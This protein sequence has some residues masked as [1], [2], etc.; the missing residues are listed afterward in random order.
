MNIERGSR[1]TATNRRRRLHRVRSTATLKQ[2]SREERGA[3]PSA[4]KRRKNSGETAQ[5]HSQVQSI[6]K[7]RVCAQDRKE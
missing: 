3:E 1:A 5:R 2:M 6:S 7:R 4:S